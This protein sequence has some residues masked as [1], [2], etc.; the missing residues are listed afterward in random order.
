MTI[1][2]VTSQTASAPLAL[3]IALIAW[4]LVLTGLVWLIRKLARVAFRK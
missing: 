4:A 3:V 2:A 1:A